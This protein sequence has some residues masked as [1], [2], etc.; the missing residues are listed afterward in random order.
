MTRDGAGRI[1]VLVVGAGG[2]AGGSH[3][4]AL[5]A[6]AE[7]VELVGVVDVDVDRATAFAREWEIPR[8]FGDLGEALAA[9]RPTLT[10][11]CTPPMSHAGAITRCL[12]G[13]SWVWCEKPPTLSL[14]EY[15]D[16]TS[17]EQEGGPYAGFVFQH[18]FGSAGRHIR[19]A[20]ERG[21]FG[22]P[23]LSVCHTLWFRPQAYYD[24]PWRGRWDTEGGGPTMGHGIH[25]MDLMLHLL[26]DWNEVRAVAPRLCRNV[27]TE[28]VSAAILTMANGMIV[29]VLN[30]ILSPREQSY[31]RIDFADATVELTHVYGYGDSDWRITA[32]PH[33]RD[34]QRVTAWAP[35]GDV[36]SS[37]VAALGDLLDS[38]E[39]GERPSTSGAGGRAALELAAGLYQSA[40]TD[41]PV[42]RDELRAGNPFYESM[43]GSESRSGSAAR[44]ERIGA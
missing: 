42:H 37:H 22:A 3:L 33:V 10:H 13:G 15:D 30:S 12:A 39:R 32:A 27:D 26:G 25:Q 31:L 35:A 9:T 17:G 40:F 5:R 34:E 16:A 23:L 11:I 36:R 4:P 38:I 20:V 28:D 43:S 8:A 2:I 7:R 18:R 41:K 29:T 21:S 19:A 24:V 6:H 1:S 44:P 14:R